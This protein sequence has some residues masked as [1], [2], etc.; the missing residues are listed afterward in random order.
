MS[1]TIY[2]IA[3][4]SG[5]SVSTVSKVLNNREGV[6]EAVRVKVLKIAER[7]GYF[8]YIKARS[9]GIFRQKGKYIAEIFGYATPYLVYQISS[10]ISE[11]LNNSRYYEIKFVITDPVSQN[12]KDKFT[13]FFDHLI[14][15]KDVTAL[16]ASFIEIDEK[17][18]NELKKNNIFTVLICSRNDFA[19]FVDID[20]FNSAYK[21]TEYLIKT[22]CKKIGLITPENGIVWNKRKEGFKKALN[23][24]GLIYNPD[25][26]EYEDTF[27]IEDTKLATSHLIERNKDLDAIIFASDWQAYA[28]I[29]YLKEK[30]IKIPDDI[31]II[32][33]DDLEFSSLIE[34]PLTTI[35]QPMKKMGQI[36]SNIILKMLKNNK[37]LNEHIILETELIIRE[38]TRKL[39]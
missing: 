32:G 6:S 14:R 39:S 27:K 33:F 9:T 5:V 29:K 38:T 31:S 1:V 26:I 10:G 22:G 24:Y 2:D 12:Q 21:A 36:A 23:D 4:R 37:F 18:I 3:K 25:L 35:R 34:P 15:D 19:S 11:I 28:G 16:I 20:D 30:N 13:L 8:P 7:L 17:V